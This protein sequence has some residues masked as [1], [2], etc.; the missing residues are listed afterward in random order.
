MITKQFLSNCV[1]V[2]NH[3]LVQKSAASLILA[4]I[5]D[6]KSLIK[7][8]QLWFVCYLREI[9]ALS[10]M[11]CLV[12]IIFSL[13][14]CL[15]LP[16]CCCSL[17]FSFWKYAYISEGNLSTWR[18]SPVRSSQ[19]A[20]SIHHGRV[21]FAPSVSQMLSPS[22]DRCVRTVFFSFQSSYDVRIVERSSAC[23]DGNCLA[24]AVIL[25]LWE[26]LGRLLRLV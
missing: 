11:I 9:A 15:Y 19:V 1:Y 26:S 12:L 16:F 22:T 17:L 13:F 6:R 4:F 7:V 20:R 14:A 18:I 24:V 25:A 21:V 8:K 2:P 10:F 5:Q 23:R 3:L